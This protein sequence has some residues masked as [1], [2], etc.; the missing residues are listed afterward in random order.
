MPK[1]IKSEIVESLV[2]L[3]NKYNIK[4]GIQFSLE[5]IKPESA[6]VIMLNG[7]SDIPQK[8]LNSKA[9]FPNKETNDKRL[10]W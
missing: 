5:Q 3:N 10:L 9:I 8:K 1:I 7:K 2:H 6:C 4:N